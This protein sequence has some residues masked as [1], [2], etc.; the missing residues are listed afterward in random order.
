M[1]RL[2]L[3]PADIPTTSKRVGKLEGA[4][5]N[6]KMFIVAMLWEMRKLNGLIK[7][8]KIYLDLI[9]GFAVIAILIVV[10]ISIYYSWPFYFNL[11]VSILSPLLMITRDLILKLLK[12]K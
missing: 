11:I 6:M 5:R 1:Y 12:L 9:C 4:T 10:L 7:I 3:F 8:Y 2:T